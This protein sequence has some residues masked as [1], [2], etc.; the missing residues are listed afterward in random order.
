VIENDGTKIAVVANR[1]TTNGSVLKATFSNLRGSDQGLNF[2]YTYSSILQHWKKLLGEV[3]ELQSLGSFR[4][5]IG[6]AT[7]DLS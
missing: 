7:A 5:W 2:C 6:K 4:T 1:I 3:V